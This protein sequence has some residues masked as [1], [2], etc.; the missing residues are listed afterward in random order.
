MKVQIDIHDVGHGHC[1]V[2]TAP[3]GQRIMLDCGTRSRDGRLWWPSIHHFGEEFAMMSLLNLDEDHLRDFGPVMQHCK[4]RSVLTNP[5]I[6]PQEFL[7]LKKQ[8]MGPG[9]KAYF[10]WLN[11]P[12][13]SVPNTDLDLGDL[14]YQAF[15]N[16]HGGPCET[17]NDLS[18]AFFVWLGSFKMLFAGDLEA[19]GWRGMLANL[20]FRQQ[21]AGV[22]IFVASHHGRVNGCYEELFKLMKPEIIVISDDVIQ[23]ETQETTAW[24]RQRCHGA[25]LIADPS[26]RRYVMT[27]RNDGALRISGS[28]DGSWHLYPNLWVRDYQLKPSPPR[29]GLLNRGLA[30]NALTDPFGFGG[31]NLLTRR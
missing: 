21:L 16:F 30:P 6:G 14:Q 31:L 11:M 10:E 9:A 29:N 1:T 23:H 20:N 26:Q 12:R 19:K 27:T 18:V 22:N 8:G 3:N 24:Y 5:T 17:T 7:T 2:I 25:G 28:A 4:V 13:F 15:W